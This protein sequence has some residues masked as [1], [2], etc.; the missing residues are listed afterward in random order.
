M[1]L[2]LI[3][4]QNDDIEAICKL[5]HTG[6]ANAFMQ[7]VPSPTGGMPLPGVVVTEFTPSGWL[8]Y[9]AHLARKRSP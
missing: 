2:P 4:T 6:Q 7:L 5:V 8:A 1:L 9:R 3:L